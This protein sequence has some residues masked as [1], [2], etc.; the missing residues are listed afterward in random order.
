MPFALSATIRLT[1]CGV[2]DDAVVFVEDEIRVPNPEELFFV[3]VDVKAPFAQ[4]AYV[5]AV[6][7]MDDAERLVINVRPTEV[8]Q[9]RAIFSRS[10]SSSMSKI[11]Q[12]P[13]RYGGTRPNVGE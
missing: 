5:Q 1:G 13:F 10:K 7:S 2:Y 11:M 9:F 8:C 12:R 6:C 3:A 4:V